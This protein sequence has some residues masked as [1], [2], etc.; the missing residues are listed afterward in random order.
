MDIETKIELIKKPPTEEVI[1]DKE[2]RELFETKDH[3]VAYNGFEPSGPMHL[4]TGLISAFKIKDFVE[5]GVHYKILLADWHAYLNKKMGGDMVKIKKVA[6]YFKAGWEALG[7]KNVE[8][9]HAEDLISKK[10]YWEMV[11][12]ISTKTTLKRI[13]RHRSIVDTMLW[14]A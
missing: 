3:P 2:L 11:M 6:E 1:S 12:K 8:Y 14:Q 13:Q 10:E 9:I 7:V 5:A 4:G